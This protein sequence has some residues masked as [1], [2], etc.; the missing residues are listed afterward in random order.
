MVTKL[1]KIM[2]NATRSMMLDLLIL[3]KLAHLSFLFN[4]LY[5]SYGLKLHIFC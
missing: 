3:V 2:P 1:D 5:N 4:A